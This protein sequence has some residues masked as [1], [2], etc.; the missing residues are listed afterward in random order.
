MIAPLPSG[1]GSRS[2]GDQY[3]CKVRPIEPGGTEAISSSSSDSALTPRSAA[4]DLLGLGELVLEPAHQP[5]AALD[6][7]LGVEGAGQR[8]RIG[9]AAGAAPRGIS[10]AW[11]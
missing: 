1:P 8:R 3:G 2:P 11:C 9:R 7:D 4:S 10:A 5:E 6:V